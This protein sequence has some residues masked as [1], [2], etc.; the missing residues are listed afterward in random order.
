MKTAMTAI[1]FVLALTGGAYAQESGPAASGLAGNFMQA[2][3]ADVNNYCSTAQT[4]KDRRQCIRSNKDKISDTCRTFLA[5]RRALRQQKQ[6]AA[7]SGPVS[8]PQ[9]PQ[10]SYGDDDQ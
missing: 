5:D 10:S 7:Q 2:C 4:K 3:G 8:Q 6:A 1:V 9:S